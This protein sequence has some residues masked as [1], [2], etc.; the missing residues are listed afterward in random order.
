MTGYSKGPWT[1]VFGRGGHRNAHIIVDANRTYVVDFED[2]DEERPSMANGRLIAAA[3]EMYE[4]LRRLH[5]DPALRLG[6]S[7]EM[8]ATLDIIIAKID[9]D[10][11]QA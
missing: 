1:M 8:G 10:E 11:P 6:W 3:P 9:V 5:A 7:E 2:V 4:L